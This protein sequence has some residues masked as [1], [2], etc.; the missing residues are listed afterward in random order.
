MPIEYNT[1]F[2][3]ALVIPAYNEDA[4]IAQMLAAVPAGMYETVVVSDNGSSDGTADSAYAAGATVVSDEERG[5]GAACLRAIEALPDTVDAV[6]F[7]QADLSETPEEALTL[8]EPIRR[9]DADLVIGSRT[10][11]NAEPGALLPHQKFGNDVANLLVRV[12]FRHRYT[13]L[14]PYRAIRL[15]MLRAM[16]M[17]DRNYGWTVEMQ[18]RALQQGLRVI[19]V[20]VSYRRRQAGVNKVSGNL[21]ASVKAGWKILSTVLKLYV[22]G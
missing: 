15:D 17:R 8:L 4:V 3:A 16:G 20:P 11:G 21:V 9:G 2:R 7:M 19:E 13:D 10:L 22:A 12:L 5:Y 14:G 18:V 6:V 1:A